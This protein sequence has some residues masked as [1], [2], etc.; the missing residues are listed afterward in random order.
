MKIKVISLIFFSCT[1]FGAESPISISKDPGFK[2]EVKNNGNGLIT[3]TTPKYIIESKN[4]VNGKVLKKPVF[5]NSSQISEPGMPDLPSST[6]FIAVD[7]NKSYS[8]E[9]TYGS[10]RFINDVDIV[11]KGSW[12]N[13]VDEVI[14][15]EPNYSDIDNY[16]P[17]NIALISEP[18][19]MRELSL[20]TLTVSP[21]RYHPDQK[22]LEE[23]IDIE[24]ELVE[25]GN[26]EAVLFHPSKRSRAFEPLYESMIA[27]YSSLNRENIPYQRP[28]ILYVLPNNIGN[29]LGTVEVLMDWK[30]RMGYEVNYISSS[31][32]VNNSNNL[33][34][35]I[36]TAYEG[37]ENPP[38][39]VT[40]VGDAEGSYDIPTYFENWSGYNLSL[41][42][43]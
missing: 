15:S 30:K 2:Y 37:W 18:M 6:T 27:N 22:I 36:E 31:N 24:V 38:E 14:A 4:A 12:D 43:I 16:Y 17:A 1:L 9:V 11:A 42:H 40:I 3:Y 13:N 25:N 5:S 23:F 26:R 21:F 41:I 20:L 34:N 39:Y 29:L 33:K 35:Y 7:P 10:S 32:I 8:I 28:S 19:A